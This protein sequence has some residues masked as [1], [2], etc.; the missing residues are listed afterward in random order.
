MNLTSVLSDIVL[1]A[2]VASPF[3][4]IFVLGEKNML[5]RAG[6][7]ERVRQSK[8]T[9]KDL[10]FGS[11]YTASTVFIW[12]LFDR[13]DSIFTQQGWSLVYRDNTQHGWIYFTLSFLLFFLVYDLWTFS[14]H[15]S[16][17]HFKCLRKFHSV[18][19]QNETSP[20][21][22]FA[23]HPVEAVLFRLPI[24]LAK[25]FVPLPYSVFVWFYIIVIAHTVYIHMGY[26]FKGLS[27]K[28]ILT[29]RFHSLHHRNPHHNFGLFF[30]IWDTFFGT[31]TG[32][33]K[34]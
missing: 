17:H 30:G 5:A 32:V 15:F 9:T 23:F 14:F 29:S 34:K 2:L 12:F 33:N 3:I 1:A 26:D 22:A 27:T 18:H 28:F 13:L 24:T 11:R 4:L 25:L 6:R 19:H 10:L 8:Y 21:G 31:A 16:L 7:I 20:M